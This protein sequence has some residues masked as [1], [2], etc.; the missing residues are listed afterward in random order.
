[1]KDL[2]YEE[3]YKELKQIALEIENESVSVDVL[4]ARVKRAS[5]L[6]TYCQSKLRAT[7]QEVNNIIRQMDNKPIQE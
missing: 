1:M 5:E 3:A 2:S 6:I 7:E 4:A